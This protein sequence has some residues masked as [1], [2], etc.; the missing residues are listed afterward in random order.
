LIWIAVIEHILR[1]GFSMQYWH[2]RN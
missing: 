1:I 2:Y